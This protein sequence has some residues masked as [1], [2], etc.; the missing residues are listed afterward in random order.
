MNM[1]K[2]GTVKLCGTV[3]HVNVVTIPFQSGCG[4]LCE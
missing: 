2:C 4:L 3:E 1:I